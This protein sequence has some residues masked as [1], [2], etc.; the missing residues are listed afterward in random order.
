MV[1]HKFNEIVELIIGRDEEPV[2]GGGLDAIVKEGV[3]GAQGYWVPTGNGLRLTH[4][5]IN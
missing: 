1:S 5:N 2:V 3:I 4:Y